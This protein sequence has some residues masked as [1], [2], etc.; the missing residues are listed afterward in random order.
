M[1]S[2]SAYTGLIG[3]GIFALLLVC[4]VSSGIP[5]V[6]VHAHENATHGHS[7]NAHDFFDDHGAEEVDSEDGNSDG[8]SFHAHEISATSLGVVA[9][10]SVESAVP[11]HS[12]SYIPPPYRW[13]PD[14]VIAPLYRP[15]IA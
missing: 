12:H 11:Q 5:M 4:V 7:H 13:L 15:P 10:G 3:K 8:S 2:N 14:N 1:T 9:S 6:E